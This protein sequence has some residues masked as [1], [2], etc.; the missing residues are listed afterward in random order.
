MFFVGKCTKKFV[1]FN[2]LY[3][4]HVV[5]HAA[6][7][8]QC[9][10][11]PTQSAPIKCTKTAMQEHLTQ[12]HSDRNFQEF[13][14]FYCKMGFSSV[15]EIRQHMA[16]NHQSKFLFVGSRWNCNTAKNITD[17]IQILYIGDSKD[18]SMYKLYTCS[19]FDA[20]NSMD[21]R[22]L[23][24]NNQL[25]KLNRIQNT[26]IK[27]EYC[28]RLPHIS[29]TFT[30]KFA[31]EKFITLE[32]YLKS[33]PAQSAIPSGSK[34]PAQKQKTV[35]FKSTTSSNGHNVTLSKH[36]NNQ[37]TCGSSQSIKSNQ[38]KG[39]QNYATRPNI[40]MHAVPSTSKLQT[41][42]NTNRRDPFTNFMDKVSSN[43]STRLNIPM[44]AIPSTSK[45]PTVH[46]PSVKYICIP[47]GLYED[48]ITINETERPSRQCNSCN[49]L[50]RIDDDR[51]LY[52]FVDHFIRKHPCTERLSSIEAVQNHR[53]KY[54]KRHPLVCLKVQKSN[55]SLL[56]ELLKFRYE[57]E[58][59]EQR[60][61]T[62]YEIDLHIY[63]KH[64]NLGNQKIV[65]ETFTLRID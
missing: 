44:Q 10:Y 31:E 42:Q 11:C 47:N 21:P 30:K 40:S 61:D 12:R 38:E 19:N 14:C 29:Y 15:E 35:Q 8:L 5:D 62:Y 32:R 63:T 7:L 20:L 60:F 39:N 54:H 4:H 27:T 26:R 52:E 58:K 23:N 34:Q 51:D 57:C 59:C 28:G 46:I 65:T 1:C 49:W 25:Q 22:E 33:H 9:P 17:E 48:L 16:E 18:Y 2:T 36:R 41:N 50:K 13:Q 3:A 64:R 6:K 45:A 55:D 56:Y 24:P 43:H 37:N 53:L